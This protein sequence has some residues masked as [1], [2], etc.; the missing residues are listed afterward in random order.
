MSGVDEIGEYPVKMMCAFF[1]CHRIP[2]LFIKSGAG[3]TL[4]I[5]HNG[6]IFHFHSIE[7]R[8]GAGIQ[9]RSI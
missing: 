6:L 2:A 1:P 9:L 5:F 8:T 4:H 3:A 7:A